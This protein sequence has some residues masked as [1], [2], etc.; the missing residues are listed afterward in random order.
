MD[1]PGT[2]P[3][4]APIAENLF[5]SLDKVCCTCDS[6]NF[7][8]RK[9]VLSLKKLMV[10]NYTWSICQVLLRWVIYT[11]NMTLS[12]PPHQEK[13]FKEILFVITTNHKR[14]GVDNWHHILENLRFVG[15]SLPSL[16]P[17]VSSST[18]KRPS[19]TCWL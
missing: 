8:N 7:S 18:C 11:V 16:V 2:H 1:S 10:G 12:L 17:R 13:R 19:T 15:I 6:G 3:P 5:H 9:E 4:A 14:I